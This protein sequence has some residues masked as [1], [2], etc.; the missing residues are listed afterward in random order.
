MS[1][2]KET[3]R[4]TD[5]HVA[6]AEYNNASF[7]AT[8]LPSGWKYRQRRIFGWAIPWYASPKV[9]LLM[10]AFV[11]F[12]CPGM[13][14]ALGGL[15]GGGKTDAE[16]A[17]NMNTALYSCFAVFGIFGGTFVNKLGV[18]WTLAFGGVG[19]CLYAISLLVSVHANVAGFN[20]FAGAW[21]GICAGLLWTA[22][23]TIMISYPNEKQ[24][25]K[26]FAWFWAIFNMG[27]VI[28]GLIPLGQNINVKTN[29]TVSDGTYIGFIVL[30][31]IGAL[32]AVFLCNASDV[33][34]EDG[35]RVILMKNPSWK[36]ELAGLWETL[37]FEP[38]VVLLFPMFFVSNWFYIYQ[39][40]AVNGAYFDTRTKALNSLLYWLAQIFAAAIWGYLLDV[41]GVR[42]STRA[43]ITWVVLFILTFAIWGGGYKFEQRYTRQT[44]D[45]KLHPDWKAFDWSDSGY[46]GPMF[47]YIFYGFYDAAWQASIYWFMG[48]LSNSGR[49]S[50]NYVGFY[51]GIQSCGAAI[52][53]NLDARKL[54][55]EREFI[56][57]WVLLAVSLVFAAPVIF[58]KIRDHIDV[59]EDLAGTDETLA[60][61][62]PADHPEKV[63]A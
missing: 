19:Y 29:K 22:Q 62:L 43:K 63:G 41:Q 13:F 15:G 49:R 26:Y 59:E 40:N 46:V 58:L 1:A 51:K 61:I 53:N 6:P 60:D 10:V 18:K 28:G 16:L 11:C 38:F 12:M 42:R 31:A 33:I 55:F 14:N 5:E 8:A 21:L 57:N 7:D 23:G 2:D 52:V 25:G 48:A 3:M 9:Q 34:R 4:T 44:V 39:Q 24:K 30:M 35:S 36:S 47:L 20:L 56:S 17:D 54:S 32:L 27:A 45:I 37:R 50:A